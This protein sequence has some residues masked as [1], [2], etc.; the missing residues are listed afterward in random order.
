MKDGHLLPGQQVS[1]DHFLCS[2]KGRLFNSRGRSSDDSMFSGGCIFNDHASG[3]V[4]IVFQSHLNSHETIMAK[5]AFERHCQ[6]FGVV[7]QTFLMD[8][9]SAFTS[10]AFQE[11]IS[12]FNQVVRF[13]GVGGHGNNGVAERSIRTIMSISRAMLLHSA[14]HWPAVADVSL[15]PMA[16]SYAV[17]IWNHVPNLESGPKTRWPQHRFQ[18]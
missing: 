18:N 10:N 1:V 7:P 2:N 6:A 13:A 17:F 3:Y 4:H 9:G 8:N 5:E 16:V 12:R 14:I 15:W 11:H